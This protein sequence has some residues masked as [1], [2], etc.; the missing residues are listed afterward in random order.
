MEQDLWEEGVPQNRLLSCPKSPSTTWA[1]EHEECGDQSNP[2][3]RQL[4]EEI[5][6][7]SPRLLKHYGV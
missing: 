7:A 6:E 2:V 4:R 1:L 5:L 3:E